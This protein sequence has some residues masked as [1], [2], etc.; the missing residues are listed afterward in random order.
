MLAEMERIWQYVTAVVMSCQTASHMSWT[1]SVVKM[2]INSEY[3][4]FAYSSSMPNHVLHQ[5]LVTVKS[6]ETNISAKL[7][8]NLH[9]ETK[10]IAST[11]KTAMSTSHP[12]KCI[13][14][15]FYAYFNQATGYASQHIWCLFQARINW[16]G[17]ARKGIQ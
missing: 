12:E 14:V 1:A 11:A 2:M 10:D 13:T 17:C 7:R 8:Y 15:A 5:F 9:A 4:H 6:H 16:E 3:Q